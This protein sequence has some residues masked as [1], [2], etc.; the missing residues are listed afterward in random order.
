MPLEFESTFDPFGTGG[1]VLTSPGRVDGE[2]Y[3]APEDAFIFRSRT[4]YAKA[5]LNVAVALRRLYYIEE[6]L[7]RRGHEAESDILFEIRCSHIRAMMNVF[8]GDE[9][10]PK[11]VCVEWHFE[12]KRVQIT[13]PPDGDS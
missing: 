1:N 5:T 2:D 7:R 11:P 8:N 10:A 13:C 4:G 3:E 12:E 9:P 6:A